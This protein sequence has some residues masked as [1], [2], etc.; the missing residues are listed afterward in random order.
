[1][2]RKLTDRQPTRTNQLC[3]LLPWYVSDTLDEAESSAMENHLRHCEECAEELPVL[4]VVQESVQ[5]ERISV[6]TPKPN[7]EQFLAS[8]GRRN[9]SSHPSKIIW[10]TG[11]I[12]ASVAVVSLI[13]SWTQPGQPTAAPSIYQTVTS[14]ASHAAIDYVLLISL[15]QQVDAVTR[16]EAL[17][18]LAAESIAGP[19]SDGKYRVVIRLPA[20]SMAEL[21]IFRESIEAD[22]AILSAAVVAVELPVEPR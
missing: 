15:D 10:V 1:M 19:D 6:L 11:A 17:R 14:D 5:S 12:A 21:E 20:R 3:E 7:S 2:E 9:L 4:R 13:L 22:S 16:D 8:V 18:A